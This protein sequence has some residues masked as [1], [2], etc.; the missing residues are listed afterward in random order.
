MKRGR[1][2]CEAV[3]HLLDRRAL[4]HLEEFQADRTCHQRCSSS[5]SRRDLASNATALMQICFSDCIIPGAQIAA[6]CDKS[7]LRVVILVEVN[8]L[9]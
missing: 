1:A 5:D 2:G 7:H 6:R 4:K 3:E 9:H 8:A